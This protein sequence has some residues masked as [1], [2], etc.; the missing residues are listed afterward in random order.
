MKAK[1]ASCTLQPI[2]STSDVPFITVCNRTDVALVIAACIVLPFIVLFGKL[3]L[4]FG[5]SH[6][7]RF[8]FLLHFC[9]LYNFFVFT[10]F[11][12]SSFIIRKRSL[13]FDFSF[14]GHVRICVLPHLWLEA[15]LDVFLALAFGNFRTSSGVMQIVFFGIFYVFC[16]GVG[17]KFDA[18]PG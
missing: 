9:V 14:Y 13:F 16:T 15:L 8:D 5:L 1:L 3:Q 4:L 11:F 2:F 7:H 18:H 6:A 10:N 12:L 17:S